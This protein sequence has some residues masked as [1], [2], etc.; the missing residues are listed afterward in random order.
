VPGI[1][2]LHTADVVSAQDF[3]AKHTK[4]IVKPI[5]GSNSADVRILDS[6]DQLTGLE[7]SKYILEKY[8]Q[9]NEMR[10]LVLDGRVIGVHRSDYGESVAE[11]RYLERISYPEDEWDPELTAL[12]LQVVDIFGLRYAAVDYLVPANGRAVVLE[13][14]SSPGM[15]W[16]HAP[17]AGPSVPVARLFLESMMHTEA[18]TQHSTPIERQQKL[19]G[20]LYL[21]ERS[22]G[23]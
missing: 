19:P 18:V 6:A 23:A 21:E 13:V 1:P 16:F 17:S 3:L 20:A 9:G 4:I 5:K 22:M 14:N 12:S 2:F 8:I 10:Y 15:K 7:V 11:D